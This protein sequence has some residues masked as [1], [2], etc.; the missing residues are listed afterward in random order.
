MHNLLKTKN[1]L[2][3]VGF[4]GASSPE[5]SGEP[6]TYYFLLDR[7]S[8]KMDGFSIILL[9]KVLLFIRLMNFSK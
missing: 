3:W 2:G 9:L 5:A 7:I 4:G 8:F 6:G 1:P